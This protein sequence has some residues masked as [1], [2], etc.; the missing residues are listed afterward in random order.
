MLRLVESIDPPPRDAYR[1][2][3]RVRRTRDLHPLLTNASNSPVDFVRVFTARRVTRLG[4]VLPGETVEVCLCE[5]DADSVV[6]TIA[7]FRPEDGEE[8]LWRFVL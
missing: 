5:E 4:Q 8:Y 7:W 3:W 1:V 6:T 2:P